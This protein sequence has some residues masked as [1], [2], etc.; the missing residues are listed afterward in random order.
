M[1]VNKKT[2]AEVTIGIAKFLISKNLI[3]GDVT[4]SLDGMHKK[5]YPNWE[6]EIIDYNIKEKNDSGFGDV[7][8]TF[9]KEFSEKIGF[10]HLY[11]ECKKGVYLRSKSS[12]EYKLMREAIGQIATVK[13]YEANTLYAIAVPKSEKTVKLAEEW[14]ITEGIKKLGLKILLIDKENKVF[15]FDNNYT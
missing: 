14:I 11:V 10:R 6:N 4:I 2:E 7:V 12:E 15:G 8:A 1:E 13:N 9:N 5:V 3:E